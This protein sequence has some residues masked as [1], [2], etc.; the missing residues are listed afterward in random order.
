MT[1]G[2]GGAITTNDS[3]LA[4]KL[5]HLTTT[6]KIPHKWEFDHDQIGYNYRMPNINAALGCAQ[7]EQIPGFIRK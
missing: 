7:L 4:K 2:G 5:K 1:T 3:V 6:A